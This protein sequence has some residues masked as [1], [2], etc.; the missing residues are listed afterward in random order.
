M[1]KRLTTRK[2][3]IPESYL[4]R[5]SNHGPQT[6]SK[7]THETIRASLESYSWPEHV[8]YDFFLQGSYSN[9][10]NIRGDSDVDVVLKLNNCFHPDWSMLHPRDQ[11]VLE[12]AFPPGTY[13]WKDFR[14]DAF[15][16]LDSKFHAFIEQ[17]NKSIKLK[18]G[19]PRLAAD[20]VVCLEHRRYTS[21]DSFVEGIAFYALQDQRWVVNYP[22]EHRK[23][24][25]AK[26]S[27]TNN[28]YKP[29][30]RML[31]NARNYLVDARRINRRLAPSYFLECL[32]YNAPDN[33]FKNDFQETYRGIVDWMVRGDINK[34]VCQNRQQY[35]FGPSAEQW[36]LD[37]AKTLSNHLV[38]LW[39]DWG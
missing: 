19:P 35:L 24:G 3:A 15:A 26:N 1:K 34:A 33:V 12:K 39:N 18:A 37:D 8:K 5:W 16:A 17:G 36:S 30:V 38:T 9:D 11:A 29:A 32:T 25:A 20:V 4:I 6:S 27:R 14:R 23:N 31:K 7:Q 2:M 28:R 21:L 22:Q 13:Q 10:T